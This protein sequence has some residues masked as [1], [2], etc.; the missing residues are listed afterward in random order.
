MGQL[1]LDYEYRGMVTRS[2]HVSK[3][4][5]KE[6]HWNMQKSEKHADISRYLLLKL[7]QL[8]KQ[9]HIESGGLHRAWK[10]NILLYF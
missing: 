10:K 5:V 7:M 9:W 8:F 2:V 1:S 3:N 6:L 4:D